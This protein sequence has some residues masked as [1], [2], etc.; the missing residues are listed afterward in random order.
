MIGAGRR[1]LA[2]G[3]WVLLGTL[4]AGVPSRAAGQAATERFD[5]RSDPEVALHHF[6]LA[7]ATTEAG[8]WPPWAPPLTESRYARLELDAAEAR[9]WDAAVA[10]YADAVGR[11]LVFDRGLV[12]VRDHLAGVPRASVPED[13]R[14]L[15]EAVE[16]AL[17]VY[18]RHWWPEHDHANRGWIESLAPT[19]RAAEGEI[20]ERMAAAYGGS[21]PERRIP[22]DVVPYANPVG[23]YSTRGR[24]TVGSLDP[25]LRM[26]HALEMVFHEASHIDAMEGPLRQALRAAFEATGGEEPD[27]LWHDAIF[28]TTGEIVRL[29]LES[30]GQVDYEHYGRMTGIYRRGDRWTTELPAFEAHWQSFLSRVSSDPTARGAALEALAH[31][32]GR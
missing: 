24:V 31:R 16:S 23:A 1:V 17:P 7:W 9:T 15:V 26:P 30:R 18:L 25:A 3:A 8:E 21:W 29:V 20:G 27:P 13:D 6:L 4:V 12:A 2:V 19:L 5:L 32:L 28:Y 22:V 14:A 11:S 10:A